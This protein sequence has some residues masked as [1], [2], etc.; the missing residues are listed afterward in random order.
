MD[1][2]VSNI[3]TIMDSWPVSLS[4]YIRPNQPRK[5][6]VVLYCSIHI[7]HGTWH[8][9]HNTGNM[10][11][12]TSHITHH[13]SHITHHTSHMRQD[14]WHLKVSQSC[15]MISR[16]PENFICPDPE[17]FP[18]KIVQRSAYVLNWYQ[19]ASKQREFNF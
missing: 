12:D 6:M 8:I 11:H 19:N 2:N 14:T 13:R 5:F 3:V 9:T 16:A 1:L 18:T 4:L 7:T 17:L 15:A 10:K